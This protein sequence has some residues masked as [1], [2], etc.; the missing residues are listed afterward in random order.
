MPPPTA[1]ADPRPSHEAASRVKLSELDK[2]D[3]PMPDVI[4]TKAAVTKT[5][6]ETKSREKADESSEQVPVSQN[7][8]KR[9]ESIK[10]AEPT[11]K[12]K[13]AVSH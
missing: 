12:T 10:Q 6:P 11:G 5:N 4:L 8:R 13:K 1:P 2:S 7:K 3:P 9:P